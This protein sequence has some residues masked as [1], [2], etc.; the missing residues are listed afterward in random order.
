VKRLLTLSLLALF[1]VPAAAGAM[2]PKPD[3][4]VAIRHENGP[5]VATSP[6]P[7]AVIRTITTTDGSSGNTTLALVLAS[8]ALGIALGGTAYA[9][10]RLR[11]MQRSS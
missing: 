11:P 7:P 6:A 5:A 3:T 9:T 2:K 8:A 1:L 10:Y 4:Y